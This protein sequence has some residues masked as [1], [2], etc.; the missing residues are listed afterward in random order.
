MQI[1]DVILS[2]MVSEKFGLRG[3]NICV[4][5]WNVNKVWNESNEQ[6]ET[7]SLGVDECESHKE[8]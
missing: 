3:K 2:D 8:L 7:L 6:T 4:S 1:W 5:T